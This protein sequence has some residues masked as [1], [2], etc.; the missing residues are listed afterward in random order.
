MSYPSITEYQDAVQDP[1]N[2][3]SDQELK[4]GNVALS[5]LGLPMPMSGGFA[6]TYKVQSGSKKFALRCFHREVPQVQLD[7]LKFQQSS[8]HWPATTSSILIS[9]AAAFGSKVN[10]IR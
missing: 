7:I 8:A 6:L 9:R 4:V 3:F 5:P 10:H 1:R 2:T